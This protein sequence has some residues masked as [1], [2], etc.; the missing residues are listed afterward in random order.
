MRTQ[1]PRAPFHFLRTSAM[2]TVILAL[3][4]GAHLAGG[5][6]LPAPAILL[7]VLALTT[8]GSTAATRLRLG[9]PAMAGL[10]GG[11]QLGLHE[12]FTAFGTPG[13]AAAGAPALHAGHLAGADVLPAALGHAHAAEPASGP[14][15]LAAHAVATLVCALLL[16]KGEEALWALAAWLRPLAAL[17]R[18]IAPDA[19]PPAFASFPTAAAP[20]PPWRNLRQDSRRGPPPG[21]VLSR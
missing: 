3:A 2:A 19:V 8:L 18:A 9:F 16:A 6:E 17:P 7:A 20:R 5:G 15:M 4:S 14:L 13:A 11:G 12:V 10:L 1:R 21:V